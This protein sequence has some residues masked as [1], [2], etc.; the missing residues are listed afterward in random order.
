MSTAT[1]SHAAMPDSTGHFG[2]Y[3]GVFVPETLVHALTQLEAEYAKH[4]S[5]PR[6]RPRI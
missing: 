2:P 5:D 6:F 3:G 1:L 4:K